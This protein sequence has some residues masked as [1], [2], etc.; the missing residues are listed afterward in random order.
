[1][2]VDYLSLTG[3]RSYKQLDL[4]LNPGVSVFVGPN[5]TGK[6]NIV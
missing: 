3:F 5:G 2:Y 1:M 4:S 6:T